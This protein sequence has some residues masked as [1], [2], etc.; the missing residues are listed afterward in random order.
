MNKLIPVI[1]ICFFA[2]G[3]GR[4]P[5][6]TPAKQ[7][8]LSSAAIPEDVSY[9]IIKSEIG[10]GQ[11]RAVDVRINKRVPEDV[12]RSISLKIKEQDA[13]DHR[14]TVI[15]FRLPDAE[16][17]PAA[18]AKAHFGPDLKVEII[19]LSTEQEK[20]ISSLPSDAKR[21]VIG[22][23]LSD[24]PGYRIVFF[25]L[26]DKIYAERTWKDASGKTFELVAKEAPGGRRYYEKHPINPQVSQFYDEHWV[27]DATGNLQDRNND[28]G[29][30][31]L[32]KFP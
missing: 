8:A 2:V 11:N 20:K 18:W 23:W 5:Q 24:V 6:P 32:K 1:G 13:G 9:S 26:D 19:G 17:G 16:P 14:I 21:E 30:T 27:I 10:F 7:V 22:S 15:F 28:G 12:L 29:R 31:I 3:C 4:Q 25:R